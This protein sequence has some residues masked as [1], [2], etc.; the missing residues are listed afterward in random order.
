M[1]IS[2]NAIKYHIRNILDKTGL[3]N[4]KAL[5]TYRQQSR[6]LEL[7][8]S[9]N[10]ENNMNTSRT[11]QHIGQITRTVRDIEISKNWYEL[12]LELPHLYT[13]GSMAFFD[14]NGTRLL[15]NQAETFN[16][17][18]S[19]LYF[20]VADIITAIDQLEQKGV[21][22]IAAPHKIHQHEDGTEEWMAFFKDPDDRPLAYMCQRKG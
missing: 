22:V 5:Q 14:C 11:I 17:E 15:L 21:E 9:K 1:N 4:K 3:P 8:P 7:H 2:V 20:A 18:E 13:Y 19:I 16:A 10:G 12:V 6:H